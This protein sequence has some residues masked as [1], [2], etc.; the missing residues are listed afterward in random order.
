MNLQIKAYMCVI[1]QGDLR[2]L[3]ILTASNYLELIT[4][5]IDNIMETQSDDY[6]ELSKFQV[7]NSVEFIAEYD[8][9][10]YREIFNEMICYLASEGSEYQ[11]KIFEIDQE[12]RDKQL[13]NISHDV[14]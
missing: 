8:E 11:V 13:V 7:P 4:K 12:I 9:D 2:D 5:V 6:P 14:F 3:N 1:T 10:D